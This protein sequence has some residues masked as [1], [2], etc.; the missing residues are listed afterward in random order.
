MHHF[1]FKQT[2]MTDYHQ[3]INLHI[4]YFNCLRLRN[5][6]KKDFTVNKQHLI[7]FRTKKKFWLRLRTARFVRKGI[8]NRHGMV[9]LVGAA[10]LGEPI[11]G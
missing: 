4:L 2:G 3:F 6:L 5:I 11:F 10:R 1:L 7:N 8:F 9:C